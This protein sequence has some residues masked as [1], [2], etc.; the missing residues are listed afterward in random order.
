MATGQL[1]LC[2]IDFRL[3]LLSI[4]FRCKAYEGSDGNNIDV[5]STDV[6]EIPDIGLGGDRCTNVGPDESEC[7]YDCYDVSTGAGSTC[8]TPYVFAITCHGK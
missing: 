6:Y 3:F 4:K 2:F 5:S 7:F 8:G 1:R